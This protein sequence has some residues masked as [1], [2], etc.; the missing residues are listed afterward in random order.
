MSQVVGAT[1]KLVASRPA[2][3]TQTS[4]PIALPFARRCAYAA[5]PPKARADGNS[6]PTN[7]V[8]TEPIAAA[9]VSV[10]GLMSVK[11]NSH[12]PT[13]IAARVMATM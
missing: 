3:K 4:C 7:S 6:Q 9:A 10:S 13:E 2:A 5:M 8:F 12:H 11:E 1:A